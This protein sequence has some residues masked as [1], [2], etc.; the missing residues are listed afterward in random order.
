MFQNER[1]GVIMAAKK[2]VGDV[3]DITMRGGVKKRCVCINVSYRSYDAQPFFEMSPMDVKGKLRYVR[4]SILS[5][6][7]LWLDLPKVEEVVI[8][9]NRRLECKKKG[10]SVREHIEL[11]SGYLRLEEEERLQK[12]RKC[13]ELRDEIARLTIEA[14]ELEEPQDEKFPPRET[15][16]ETHISDRHDEILESP[17]TTSETHISDRHDEILESPETTSETHE[18]DVLL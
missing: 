12:E 9:Y 13:K 17:E 5:Q 18:D 7:I 8:G 14:N 6:S 15:T 2:H 10:K 16:S 3:A 1:D 4:R 11:L